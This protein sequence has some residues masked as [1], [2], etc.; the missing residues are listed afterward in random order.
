VH[1]NET[2][3]DFIDCVNDVIEEYKKEH[4]KETPFTEEDD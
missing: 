3:Q 4:I 1:L 2:V